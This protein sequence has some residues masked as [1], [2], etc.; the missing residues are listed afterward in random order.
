MKASAMRVTDRSDNHNWLV[1]IDGNSRLLDM[2]DIRAALNPWR[3]ELT[4]LQPGEKI[5]LGRKYYEVVLQGCSGGV[6]EYERHPNPPDAYWRDEDDLL[7]ELAGNNQAGPLYELG[8]DTLP[9]GVEDITGLIHDEPPRVFW[10]AQTG[11]LGIDYVDPSF[12]A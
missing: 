6:A 7:C 12:E 11:Y 4:S 10:A 2:D 3:D 8:V 9:D 5:T 1:N